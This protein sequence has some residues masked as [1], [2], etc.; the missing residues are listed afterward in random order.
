MKKSLIKLSVCFATLCYFTSTAQTHT[1]GHS[2][3]EGL[4]K[5]L[6][7]VPNHIFNSDSLSGFNNDALNIYIVNE[8]LSIA[9]AK[10]YTYL[11]K[12]DYV[13]YKYA[14]GIYAIPKQTTTSKK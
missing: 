1:P 13:N 12:R 14:L 6:P 8:K 2:H 10:R 3:T 9:D 11:K 7:I 5:Q 4:R